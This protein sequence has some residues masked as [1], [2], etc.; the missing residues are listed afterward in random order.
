MPLPRAKFATAR[1]A[2]MCVGTAP[3]E[4]LTLPSEPLTMHLAVQQLA[5]RASHHGPSPHSHTMHR[6]RP[7]PRPRLRPH[8]ATTAFALAALALTLALTAL[9]SEHSS[10]CVCSHARED[11]TRRP[12]RPSP[13]H[14]P[15]DHPSAPT[16]PTPSHAAHSSALGSTLPQYS[17][18]RSPSI[19]PYSSPPWP[20]P[21]AHRTDQEQREVSGV[22]SPD[23]ASLSLSPWPIRCWQ[24]S[25]SPTPIAQAQR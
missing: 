18:V 20:A 9:A 5:S 10:R 15:G 22:Q 2:T 11:P 4:P 19:A 21:E 24:A 6:P 23:D 7:R 17:P 12:L 25:P 8:R 3:S 14:K 16:L 13:R 1:P